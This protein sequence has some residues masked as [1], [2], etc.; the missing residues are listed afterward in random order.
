MKYSAFDRELLAV[1]SLV[2]HFRFFLEGRKFS[3]FSDH[4]RLAT[5]LYRTSLPLS[6]WVQCQLAFIAE[7][8]A[9]LHYLPGLSNIVADALS[10]PLLPLEVV[11]ALTACNRVPPLPGIDFV[12]MGRS[13]QICPEVAALRTSSSLVFTMVPAADI[14]IFGDVSTGVFRPLVPVPCVVRFLMLFILWA[15]PGCRRPATSFLRVSSGGAWLSKSVSGCVS[16]STVN[17]EKIICHVTVPAD[18]IPVPGCSFA[19]IHIDLVGP[20]PLTQGFNFLL[21]VMDRTTR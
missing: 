4:N 7:L 11:A 17:M 10:C 1:Y 5:A 8:T 21:T 9:D 3:I 20:L 12:E 16:V 6:A 14:C 15:I 19:H 18:P 2:K 13:Q